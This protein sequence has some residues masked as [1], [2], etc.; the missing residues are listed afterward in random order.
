MREA[1]RLASRSPETIRR[2][3][4]GGRLRAQRDGN[5]LLVARTDVLR[6]AG[7]EAASQAPSLKEWAQASAQQLRRGQLGATASDLLFDDRAEGS[8]AGR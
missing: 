2:W 8:H 4:W 5:R 6:L 3:V 1:G 7:K